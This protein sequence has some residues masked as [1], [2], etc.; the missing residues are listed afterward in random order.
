MLRRILARL[1]TGI[2]VMWLSVTVA[3]LA[4]H[5]LPGRIEDV[6]VGDMNYPGLKEAVAHEWG[7]DRP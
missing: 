1:A 2:A 4:L 7:L 5:A 3:F 6:L